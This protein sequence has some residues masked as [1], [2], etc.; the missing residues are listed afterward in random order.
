MN[1]ILAFTFKESHRKIYIEEV[2]E[3]ANLSEEAFCRFFKLRTRKTY[4]NFLNEMR[5]SQAC[6]LLIANESSIQDICFQTGFSNLSN[7][8]RI[9]KK[10]TGKTPSQYIRIS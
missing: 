1:N 2:A 9:F 6:K 10:V 5:V 7:F 8:N 3:V 4:T